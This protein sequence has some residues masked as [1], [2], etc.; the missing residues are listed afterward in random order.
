MELAE[1][2]AIVDNGSMRDPNGYYPVAGGELVGI[3]MCAECADNG[4][5]MG[6]ALEGDDWEPTGYWH[7]TDYPVHCDSCEA[8]IVTTLTEEGRA[9]VADAIASGEGRKAVLDAWAS[10]WKQ[11]E[12]GEN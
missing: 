4:D 7:E 10:V 6:A 11:T 5:R 1:T 3:A 8:L 9:Y 2:I 12:E